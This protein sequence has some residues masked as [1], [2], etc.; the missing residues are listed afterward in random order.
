MCVGSHLRLSLKGCHVNPL[1]SHRQVSIV[2]LHVFGVPLTPL[3]SFPPPA[4]S[5]GLSHLSP[6]PQLPAELDVATTQ[7]ILHLSQ[8]K[9]AAIDCEDYDAAKAMK[10]RMERLMGEVPRLVEMERRKREAIEREDFDEA[11]R[12][13]KE[14]E[15]IR[16]R[17]L[18]PLHR[19][20]TDARTGADDERKESDG[21]SSRKRP[22]KA[23]GASADELQTS[24][25]PAKASALDDDRPI[26]PAK[27][28]AAVASS[29]PS[30]DE[31]PV[32]PRKGAAATPSA[33]DDSTFPVHR[34]SPA[35]E[36]STAAAGD[37]SD[38]AAASASPSSDA[39]YDEERPIH[40]R[41]RPS[42]PSKKAG[43]AE[44]GSA[45]SEAAGD[46]RA[47]GTSNAAYPFDPSAL[48]P[49]P[50]SSSAL[51]TPEPIPASLSK[52]AEP[53]VVLFGSLL[54][55]QL[56]SRHWQLRVE[57]LGTIAT[58]IGDAASPVREGGGWVREVG[59]VLQRV[60]ADK[61]VAVFV[62]AARLLEL[63]LKEGGKKASG[64]GKE[65]LKTVVEGVVK[66]MVDRLSSSNG[67]ERDQAAQVLLFLALHRHSTPSLV[68][69]ALLHSLK[70]K[71]A[72]HP[73]PLRGRLLLLHSLVLRFRLA[74]AA[75]LTVAGLMKFTVPLLAHRDAAVRDAAFN[76]V[77]SVCREGGGRGKVEPFLK[78]VPIGP[79]QGCEARI[80]DVMEGAVLF[81]RV[82]AP[83]VAYVER[84]LVKEGPPLSSSTTA[85][86]SPRRAKRSAEEEKEREEPPLSARR[87]DKAKRKE[88]SK[89]R[90]SEP[91]LSARDRVE[92]GSDG[93]GKRRSHQPNAN[94][95]AGKSGAGREKQAGGREV[96]ANGHGRA[97]EDAKLQ[98]PAAHKGSA[99][100]AQLKPPAGPPTRRYSEEVDEEEYVD[101]FPHSDDGDRLQLPNAG[102]PSQYRLTHATA[103]AANDAMD[104]SALSPAPASPAV[105]SS[106][107][108]SPLASQCQFCGLEDPSFTEDAL[109]LHYWQACPMLLSCPHC[110]QVVEIPTYGEHLL[111]EC[112]GKGVFRACT[113]C[114]WVVDDQGLDEH[115]RECGGVKEGR[116]VCQ[117]CC[118]EVE[119]SDEGWR[120]HLLDDTCAG[121][122]RTAGLEVSG[123]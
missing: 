83:T 78:D 38:A 90:H 111:G 36:R 120:R 119:A 100:E 7:Y 110:E 26:K 64:G 76:V 114:Q 45:R 81:P 29:A 46:D 93:E 50:S 41:L 53:L 4:S 16:E 51:P 13:K 94:G 96:K 66:A 86:L 31:L 115:Q 122:A 33:D 79:L 28:A 116:V 104:P 54:T 23:T 49:S 43:A 102:S 60:M 103:S 88:P 44:L 58:L 87:A 74:E 95:E 123:S 106:P 19:H 11:K 1:N 108:L 63:T 59:R 8:L 77:A 117:L 57:A 12:C 2:A 62:A 17:A 72:D 105:P 37:P 99:R 61:V 5:S 85:V 107:P 21:L 109:D 25:A 68:S 92:H 121:N 84:P 18:Q 75:G 71:E 30:H 89:G 34:Q 27:S 65:E 73:T 69:A 24:P 48:P 82:E 70:K 35:D 97:P 3:P 56:L 9:G 32:G 113:V 80:E 112:E 98:R 52:E 10:E 42:A 101:D 55:A 14:V 22:S 15:A 20:S 47:I 67:R 40:S 91:P 6:A 118:Q 39:V